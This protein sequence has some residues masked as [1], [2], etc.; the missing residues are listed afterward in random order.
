MRMPEAHGLHKGSAQ[1]SH[2]SRGVMLTVR[3]ESKLGLEPSEHRSSRPRADE[4]PAPNKRARL[5]HPT[6][7]V[8]RS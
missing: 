3:I 6:Q 2:E 4:D 8:G 1:R 7:R 5:R